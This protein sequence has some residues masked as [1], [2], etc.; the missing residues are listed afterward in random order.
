MTMPPS[1]ASAG[2]GIFHVHLESHFKTKFVLCV[3]EVRLHMRQRTLARVF[4]RV[5][6]SDCVPELAWLARIINMR[7]KCHVR[8]SV[9]V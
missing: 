1:V 9:E 4:V 2:H 3:S 6:A 7:G 8:S 5:R